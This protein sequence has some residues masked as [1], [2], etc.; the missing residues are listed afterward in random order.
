MT[1][2]GISVIAPAARPENWEA[3]YQSIGDN[4]IPFEVVF[5]GPNAP[6]NPLPD[7]FRYIKSNTKP[8]QAAEIACR[9]AIYP[10]VLIIGDDF[11]FRTEHPLD[12]AYETYVEAG[13]GKTLVSCRYIPGGE[14]RTQNDH[15]FII[16]DPETPIL[17]LCTLMSTP[18]WRD[19]GGIDKNFIA[20]QWD[21]DIAMRVMATGGKVVFSDVIVEEDSSWGRGS[22][23][24]RDH[25]STDHALR[26]QL[27]STDGKVH[28]NRSRP[29]ESFSDEGILARSQGPAGRWNHDSDFINGLITSRGYYTL[30][31]WNSSIRG[32]L[33]RFSV[34]NL[35]RYLRR[36][37]K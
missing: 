16:D 15:R 23:L 3:L 19:I 18:L 25:R 1:I 29:V 35:P 37:V 17:P 31:T 33:N 27:W 21:V 7:N 26:F 13:A 22:T 28:F 14:A 34:R 30:K 36:M 2:Q 11:R 8:A 32:R 20:V 9:N 6:K 10:L 5:V 4:D 24:D 12:K